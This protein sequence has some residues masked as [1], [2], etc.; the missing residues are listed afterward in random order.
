MNFAMVRSYTPFDKLHELILATAS[1][2][3]KI[4][5]WGTVLWCTV[6]FRIY[7]P[8]KPT[9]YSLLYSYFC[10]AYPGNLSGNWFVLNRTPSCIWNTEAIV[11]HLVAWVLVNFFPGDLC[12]SI[13]KRKPFF[14]ILVFLTTMDTITTAFNFQIVGFSNH[15]ARGGPAPVCEAVFAGLCM[16]LTGT[17]LRHFQTYGA[18]EGGR[19]IYQTW[20]SVQLALGSQLVF[21]TLVLHGQE[22]FVLSHLRLGG[23]PAPLKKVCT[24]SPWWVAITLF[25]CI[26][27][28]LPVVGDALSSVTDCLIHVL[29]SF[30]AKLGLVYHHYTGLEDN[31]KDV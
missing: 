12:F 13:I 1:S 10:V 15:L 3:P 16:C 8:P 5:L 23:S 21:Y 24:D 19:R 31:K 28:A 18:E 4:I 6:W 2:Y 14:N 20:P 11:T 17:F 30:C 9:M 27:E 7:S 25:V 26:H 29:C 22:G